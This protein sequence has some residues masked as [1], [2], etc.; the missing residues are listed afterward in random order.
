MGTTHSPTLKKC[1][2]S[3]CHLITN[4]FLIAHY[5]FRLGSY[6]NWCWYGCFAC[7]WGG[8]LGL[9]SGDRG[10][11]TGRLY[12]LGWCHTQDHLLLTSLLGCFGADQTVFGRLSLGSL[13]LCWFW[14]R[15]WS[16]CWCPNWCHSWSWLSLTAWTCKERSSRLWQLLFKEISTLLISTLLTYRCLNSLCFLLNH[17]IWL[18]TLLNGANL[19]YI[20]S[21]R[22]YHLHLLPSILLWRTLLNNLRLCLLLYGFNSRLLLTCRCL[23]L[24]NRS[25]G[26]LLR[27]SDRLSLVRRNRLLWLL[28]WRCNSLSWLLYNFLYLRSC[29]LNN[30]CLGVHSLGIRWSG[31]GLLCRF[32]SS[33]WLTLYLSLLCKRSEERRVEV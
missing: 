30:G 8:W 12:R 7:L 32:R 20:R 13:L 17:H 2:L 19:A 6:N 29:L 3:F 28:W 21:S 1:S 26:Y 4:G 10:R 33:G 16:W 24:L 25:G 11:R 15:R 5:V 14:Y 31:H 18:G 9:G 22:L 23:F 27:L